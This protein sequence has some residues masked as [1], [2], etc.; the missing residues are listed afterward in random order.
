MSRSYNRI[1]YRRSKA[2]IPSGVSFIFPASTKHLPNEDQLR[3]VIELQKRKKYPGFW[4]PLTLDISR[5]RTM[6]EMVDALHWV[7]DD[8]RF[9]MPFDTPKTYIMDS[10]ATRIRGFI[11]TGQCT[12]HWFEDEISIGELYHAQKYEV[13]LLSKFVNLGLSK[14]CDF[15]E[16]YGVLDWVDS[17]RSNTVYKQPPDE[18]YIIVTHKAFNFMIDNKWIHDYDGEDI[19][20]PC[21]KCFGMGCA[22]VLERNEIMN[23]LDETKFNDY[24]YY[25]LFRDARDELIKPIYHYPYKW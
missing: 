11:L 7:M 15:C 12:N 10:S 19:I 17:I 14:R 8:N 16:G 4:N 3:L 13:P 20:S 2:R 24:E 1:R 22:S 6:P 9:Y 23:R 25:L 21:P 18:R 5:A